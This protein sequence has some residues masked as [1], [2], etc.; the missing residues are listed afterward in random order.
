MHYDR[1]LTQKLIFMPGYEVIGKLEKNYVNQI[2][3][4][5]N[6]VLFS[7]GFNKLRKNI[8]RVKKFEK[9]FKSFIGANY[10]HSAS[11]GTAALRI[12][13]AS[14]G[15]G[16]GD[17]VITQCFTFVATVESIVESGATPVCTEINDTLNMCP[18]DLEKKITKK[19]KAVIVVHYAS[20]SSRCTKN[21][22]NL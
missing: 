17:E 20:C 12:A 21:K 8:F 19:T 3:T 1:F 15:V 5:S 16:K 13:L 6:G 2:F 18:T 10:A 11:S 14:L 7:Q 9:K 4:K 22:K